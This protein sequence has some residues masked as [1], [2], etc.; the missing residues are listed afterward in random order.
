MKS[1]KNIKP[2]YATNLGN[3]AFMGAQPT[4][5]CRYC[6]KTAYTPNKPSDYVMMPCD[7]KRTSHDWIKC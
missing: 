2:A 7:G 1:M 4:Y 5:Q 6:G 3:G